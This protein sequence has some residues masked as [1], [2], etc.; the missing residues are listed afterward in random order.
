[1][2]IDSENK[3]RSAMTDMEFEGLMPVPDGIIDKYDRKHVMGFYS[4]I[5]A[6]GPPSFV[7]AWAIKNNVFL[8]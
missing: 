6:S 1:V 8:E 4:G 3:R 5:E 2:A 7:A